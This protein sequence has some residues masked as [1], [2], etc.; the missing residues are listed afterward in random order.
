MQ[1][2]NS[3][4][5]LH[6]CYLLALATSFYFCPPEMFVARIWRYR[7]YSSTFTTV[8]TA[9]A[10]SLYFTY[11]SKLYF[12]RTHSRCTFFFVWFLVVHFYF[13]LIEIQIIANITSQP[14]LNMV[15]KLRIVITCFQFRNKR[16]LDSSS[17]EKEHSTVNAKKINTNKRK[18]TFSGRKRERNRI[19]LITA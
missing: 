14:I 11:L 15:F 10:S 12:R 7:N 16:M 19:N 3:L 13:S 6:P 2:K 4:H 9:H 8:V 17:K 5:M 1:K 18:H